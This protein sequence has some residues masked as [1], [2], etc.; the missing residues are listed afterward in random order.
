MTRGARPLAVSSPQRSVT[1]IDPPLG[2]PLRSLERSAEEA[3]DPGDF[4]LFALL[5]LASLPGR[6]AIPRVIEG[7]L[8]NPWVVSAQDTPD[9][10]GRKGGVAAEHP[11]KVLPP[12]ESLAGL[13]VC[14]F[15]FIV[16]L[17]YGC[18]EILSS[19]RLPE[20]LNRLFSRSPTAISFRP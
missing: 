8:R 14:L 18:L 2:P 4:A 9:G 17:R 3:V 1:T 5:H 16:Q 15:E 11:Q 13:W 20:A 6:A 19:E 7:G 12:L 10:D